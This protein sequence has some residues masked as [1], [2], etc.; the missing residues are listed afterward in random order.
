M[1]ILGYRGRVY[2]ADGAVVPGAL[3][4]TAAG[5]FEIVWHCH[6]DAPPLVP[7]WCTRPDAA[8][9]RLADVDIETERGKHWSQKRAARAGVGA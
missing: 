8:L 3:E 1:T 9:E 7:L 2:D 4:V 6:R 5:V